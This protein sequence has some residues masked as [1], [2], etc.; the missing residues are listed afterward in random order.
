MP[1][2]SPFGLDGNT[3]IQDHSPPLSSRAKGCAPPEYL[4][5]FSVLTMLPLTVGKICKKKDVL[6]EEYKTFLSP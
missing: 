6:E 2:I 1:T 5:K 3:K 4:L